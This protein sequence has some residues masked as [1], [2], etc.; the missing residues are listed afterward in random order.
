MSK[1]TVPPEALRWQPERDSIAEPST[2][3]IERLTGPLGQAQAGEAVK[4]GLTSEGRN[5]HIYVRG[6]SGTGRRTLIDHWINELELPP[7]RSLD[8]CYVHN[9]SNPDR[10]RLIMLPGGQ[11]HAFQQAMARISLFVR[12]RLPEILKNDPIRSRREARKE[13][14]EREIRLKTGPLDKKL[15]KEGLTLI[16]TQSGPSSRV[17]I[18]PLIMGKPVSPEE[19]RNLV[20]QGQA[21]DEDRQAALK[22]LRDWQGEL[23]RVAN[24]ISQIWQQAIQHIDQIN[25][26]ETARIL[27]ELTAEVGRRFKTPGMEIFLREIIDDIVEKRIGRDTSHLADPTLLYGANV[28]T[29]RMDRRTMP[30]VRAT[31][32][33]VANL[34]GTIDPAWMSSGRAVTSFRGI[35]TGALLEA[36]GGILVLDAADVLAEPGS[37]RMLMR[38]LRT[39]KAE[40]VPPELGWPYSAQSLKPEPIPINVRVVLVGDRA[41]WD[42][43]CRDDRDFIHLFGVLADLDET[44]PRDREHISGYGRFLATSI[45]REGLTHFDRS[46]V[47]AMIEYGARGAGEAERLSARYG[48]LASLAREASEQAHEDGAETVDASHVRR[49]LKQRRTQ[50]ELPLQRRFRAADHGHFDLNLR[51]RIEG[52]VNTVQRSASGAQPIGL[53]LVV[54][55]TV[56][57]GLQC[58][59]RLDADRDGREFAVMLGNLLR[60]DRPPRLMASISHEPGLDGVDPGLDL[61][62]ALSLISALGQVPIRQELAVVGTLRPNGRVGVFDAINE[63]V[64]TFY[65]LCRQQGLTGQQAVVIPRANC[66]E[67]MLDPEVVKACQNDMFRVFAVD[68]VLQALELG[69]E[70]RAGTWKDG[71]FTEQST[72]ARARERLTRWSPD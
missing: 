43:L 11:G 46:G 47:Q 14:A 65:E 62:R 18:Y 63:R 6:D 39:G 23:N 2:R 66:G 41:T 19:Y 71:A 61:A 16:R 44:L 35:R 55:A 1:F 50:A 9:F 32:P 48:D 24:E 68:S 56:V 36:D 69:C 60:L 40:V 57:P 38:S 4:L 34:F 27:S 64:E 49:A 45:E 22:R 26:T 42:E 7:R 70:R 54:G 17:S 52:R 5:R 30:V 31:Q 67:L 72:L 51:G 29:S 8:F 12:D 33:S 13:S 15:A 37:W 59:I 20:A 10:P 28:L 25:A 58:D 53:P 21:R 3:S